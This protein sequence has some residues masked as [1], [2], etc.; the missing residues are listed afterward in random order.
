MLHLWAM[1]NGNW[2]YMGQRP[3]QAQD[4]I[5]P[6]VFDS[7]QSLRNQGFTQYFLIVAIFTP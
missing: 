4:N 3:A 6:G 5:T 7:L 1:V 2:Q